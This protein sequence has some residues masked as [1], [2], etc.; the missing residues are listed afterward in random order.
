[1]NGDITGPP[2]LDKEPEMAYSHFLR[3]CRQVPVEASSDDVAKALG[4]NRDYV[5]RLWTKWEWKRRREPL[6]TAT[7]D[8]VT[9]RTVEKRADGIAEKAAEAWINAQYARSFLAAELGNKAVQATRS[10]DINALDANGKVRLAGTAMRELAPRT[11][12]VSV[13]T[14]AEGHV[15]VEIAAL[16]GLPPAQQAAK[17]KELADETARQAA[18]LADYYATSD[19]D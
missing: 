13:S 12:S 6:E 11:A 15:S 10:L 8:E 17:A 1:M 4:L 16:E 5:R 7:N 19:G 3:W 9:R 18:L 14:D 2:R